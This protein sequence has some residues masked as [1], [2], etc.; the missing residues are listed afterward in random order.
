MRLQRAR[1]RLAAALRREGVTAAAVP[2]LLILPVPAPPPGLAASMAGSA[3]AAVTAGTAVGTG[4]ALGLGAVVLAAAGTGL[5]LGGGTAAD[6]PRSATAA[7]VAEAAPTVVDP[8]DRMVAL[9]AAA[10]DPEWILAR[11]AQDS[12]APGPWLWLWPGGAGRVTPADRPEPL[13]AVLDRIATATGTR[14]RVGRPLAPGSPGTLVFTRPGWAPDLATLAD[15]ARPWPGD[16]YRDLRLEGLPLTARRGGAS[17]PAILAADEADLERLV[18]GVLARGA[19]AAAE[20]RAA[21]AMLAGL[22][23]LG[24][25]SASVAALA[26]G[27]G[28]DGERSAIAIARG[29]LADPTAVADWSRD[30][31]QADPDTARR[32]VAG[33]AEHPDPGASAL[34]VRVV[35]A[36]PA[37]DPGP[38]RAVAVTTDGFAASRVAVRSLALSAGRG[39]WTDADLDRLATGLTEPVVGLRHDIARELRR[40]GRWPALP[41][42]PLQGSERWRARVLT[43]PLDPLAVTAAQAAAVA[44]PDLE[45]AA[46]LG[47]IGYDLAWRP[48]AAAVPALVARVRTGGPFGRLALAALVAVPGEAGARALA[49]L[50][51]DA[52]GEERPWRL[53]ALAAC[54]DD[55]TAMRALEPLLRAGGRGDRMAARGLMQRPG[56]VAALLAL[57]ARDGDPGLAAAVNAALPDLAPPAPDEDARALLAATWAAADPARRAA[58]LRSAGAVLLTAG[59]RSAIRIARGALDDPSAR[60]RAAALHLFARQPARADE[61]VRARAAALLATDREPR[62]RQQALLVVDQGQDPDPAVAFAAGADP[63]PEVRRLAQRALAR[64]ILAANDASLLPPLA[65]AAARDTDLEPALARIR[66]HLAGGGTWGWNDELPV[67]GHPGSMPVP[68]PDG[69]AWIDSPAAL[70]ATTG[71]DPSF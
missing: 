13:R 39:R 71:T 55:A 7:V 31:D 23:G 17:L 69:D 70:P 65:A 51:D 11:I 22:G 35:L 14:W 27:A 32:V 66:A 30:L 45:A 5:V 20:D 24:R 2:G 38:D 36:G 47:R 54:A 15:P 18:A 29:C 61:L 46:W 44:D 41:D 28:S 34:L 19:A 25:L 58:G 12:G 56:G 62:V 21:A 16:L 67:L 42:T 52:T 60:I 59:N 64:R 37:R 49:D 48:D 63:D 50:A 3:A 10:M 33:A 6:P 4:W 8:L 68:E 57:L 43:L 53:A 1:E 9:P 40:H 26:A